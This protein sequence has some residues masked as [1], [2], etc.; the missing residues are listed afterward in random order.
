MR[1]LNDNDVERFAS[2]LI[3]FDNIELNILDERIEL[4]KKNEYRI[5]NQGGYL[6]DNN[7][8]GRFMEFEFSYQGK[9]YFIALQLYMNAS[10]YYRL[11][12]FGY[13]EKV[14]MW[15]SVNLST[16]LKGN[17]INF[18]IQIKVSSPQNLSKEARSE[19]RDRIVKELRQYGLTA[20][21]KNHI[22]FGEYNIDEEMFINTTPQKFIKDLLTIALC[23][24]F[25]E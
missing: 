17:I 24:Y 9:N 1:E 10:G 21:K 12:V 7:F 23:K 22:S 13:D 16:G 25:V 20:D 2:A 15:T 6:Q 18:D 11:F 5:N 3:Q 4:N 8:L 19:R 14:R